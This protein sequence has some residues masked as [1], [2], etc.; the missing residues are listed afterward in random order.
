MGINFRDFA[1]FFWRS[2]KFIP[3][4]SLVQWHSRNITF[5]GVIEILIKN[6]QKWRQYKR[7][8]PK[9]HAIAKVYTRK[10]FEGHHM[11]KFIPANVNFGPRRSPI[12]LRKFI[13][14]KYSFDYFSPDSESFWFKIWL[15]LLFQILPN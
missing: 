12:S 11:R 7:I 13:P 5:M 9:F 1:I 10:I 8:P 3:A 14:I 15:T 6:H 2:R 4:K